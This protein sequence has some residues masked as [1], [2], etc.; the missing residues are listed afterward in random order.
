MEQRRRMQI[1]LKYELRDDSHTGEV[2]KLVD[3][4]TVGPVEQLETTAA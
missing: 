4:K 3:T 1:G 2:V